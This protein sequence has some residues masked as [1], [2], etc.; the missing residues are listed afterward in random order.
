MT[1][2]QLWTLYGKYSKSLPPPHD[3]KQSIYSLNLI[4]I[5][6]AEQFVKGG[7]GDSGSPDSYF[8]V[9][10]IVDQVRRFL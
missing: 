2:A 8:Y 10:K 1:R 6:F 3:K 9:A 4:Y 7:E 5:G